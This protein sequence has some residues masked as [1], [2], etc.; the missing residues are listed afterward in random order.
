[1]V[2]DDS[3]AKA[4]LK[5]LTKVLTRRHGDTVYK[6]CRKS[7]KNWVKGI[8]GA[9]RKVSLVLSV[10]KIDND[11]HM[12]TL[13][14]DSHCDG[15][16][17]VCLILLDTKR[18][19]F[20]QYSSYTTF[21][22][23]SLIRMMQLYKTIDIIDFADQLTWIYNA[24]SGS[25]EK[26]SW[27]AGEYELYVEGVGLAIIAHDE[28]DWTVKTVIGK[29]TLIGKRGAEYAKLTEKHFYSLIKLNKP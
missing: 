17:H 2:I 27:V 15:H 9:M 7:R 3:T 25:R 14:P 20:N 5:K 13:I 22:Q 26:G 10:N 19:E 4:T 6:D 1:M 11:V 29:D 12:L 24:L 16:F 8:V 18:C 23:H 21:S 28:E